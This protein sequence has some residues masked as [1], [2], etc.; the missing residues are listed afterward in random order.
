LFGERGLANRP[1]RLQPGIL[2]ETE[3]K[4]KG[5]RGVLE[6]SALELRLMFGPAPLKSS[7]RK[8][9]PQREVKE[10]ALKKRSQGV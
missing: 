8:R 7:K 3:K 2:Q 4:R 1:S 9:H 10:W 5:C 6:E